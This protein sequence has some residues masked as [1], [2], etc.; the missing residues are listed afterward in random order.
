VTKEAWTLHDIRRT[1]A[2]RLNE[3]GVAPYVV[4]Q[5]LG[6]SLGGRNGDL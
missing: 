5:L 2:T 1:L 3:L 6:H 4:E